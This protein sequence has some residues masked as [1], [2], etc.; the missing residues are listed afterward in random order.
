[1]K[2]IMKSSV[3]MLLALTLALGVWGVTP[4]AAATVKGLVAPFTIKDGWGSTAINHWFGP[5]SYSTDFSGYKVSGDVYIPR[6][7]FADDAVLH[8]RADISF[9]FEDIEKSGLLLSDQKDEIHIGY[10]KESNDYWFNGWDDEKQQDV[11]LP[12]VKSVSTVGDMV[13]VEF[14]DA[15]V[16]A[17]LMSDQWDEATQS[18]KPWEG[19]I[20]Q[21]NG[22]V[23]ACI[24]VGG[25]KAFSGKI[26]VSNVSVKIGDKVLDAIY[27]ADDDIG[28]AWGDI[29][30]DMGP[31]KP[32]T[33]N[34]TALSVAK[35]SVKVKAKKSSTVKVTTM[36]NGDKVKVSSSTKKVAKATY[37]NGKVT[38]KG[39]KKGK[40]TITVKANGKTKKIKVTVK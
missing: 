3:A 23:N 10:N 18:N 39:V 11:E 38:I 9:W 36:F 26:A 24:H 35:T 1:M 8:V 21:T 29:E 31:I 19:D 6:A 7:A 33:F 28:D 17:E 30:G 25:E 14:A 13:K 34:T 16:S 5:E 15:P 32:E 4:S 27:D 37:K 40:A 20:P 12:F 22:H 2:R